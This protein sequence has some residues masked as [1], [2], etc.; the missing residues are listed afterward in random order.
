MPMP[1]QLKALYERLN[2]MKNK[3]PAQN[4]FLQA[5]KAVNTASDKLRKPDRYKRIP[6]L[7]AQDRDKLMDLHKAVGKAA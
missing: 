5:I 7:L 3:T 6:H 2:K 4:A 1:E